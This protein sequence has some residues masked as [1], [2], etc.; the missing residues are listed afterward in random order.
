MSEIEYI[1]GVAFYKSFDGG[2]GGGG[3][4]SCYVFVR[5]GGAQGVPFTRS[6]AERNSQQIPQTGEQT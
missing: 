6:Q 5:L 3:G 1:N 4:G 2:G